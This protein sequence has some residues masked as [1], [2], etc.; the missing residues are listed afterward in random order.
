MNQTLKR[1]LGRR[2]ISIV[3]FLVL[4]ATSMNTVLCISDKQSGSSISPF[5]LTAG[6][7]HT[8]N[9]MQKES[10]I[11]T[12]DDESVKITV[13]SSEDII[14]ISYHINSFTSEI[15]KIH[16]REYSKIFLEDESNMKIK[17][18]PE[19]PTISQSIIIPDTAK[20]KIRVIDAQYEEY[21]NM[22]IIP[23]KGILPR[24][25][26]PEEVPY[27]FDRIYTQDTMFPP[28]IAELGEPYILRDF[29]GQVVTLYP[30]QYNPPR[31]ILRFYT[32][33]TIEI[34]PDGMDTVNCITRSE[35][36]S[37]IDTDFK[38][39]YEYHFINFPPRGRYTPVE[40]Q[41]NML[42]ITYDNFWDEMIPFVQWKN[43]KGVP[44]EMV[45]VSQIGGAYAIKTY[46]SD[47]YYDNGLTFVL[48]VG[49]VQQVPTL[50]AVGGASDPSYSYIVGYDHY[51]DLFVG[52]FS[53]QNTGQVETQ[54]ER[55]IEYEKYPQQGADWYH[56]G[57]GIASNEG[58]GDDW[59]YDW[60]HIRNI[61]TELLNYHYTLVDELYDG[62]HGGEDAPGN[63]SAG[64]VSTA[65]NNGRSVINYC[66]HGWGQGWVTTGFSN[67]HVNSLINDNM[68]PF[69][70]TVACN[71]GEFDSYTTC[72]AEAWLR[73]THG[74]EPTGAIA[75][76]AS[77]ISQYW[78]P[79]MDAQDEFVALL[80]ESYAN[81]KKNTFGGISF[82]GCMHMNDRYGSWGYDMTDT[83]HVFGDP[84][85]QVR[86]DTPAYMTVI[87]DPSIPVGSLTFEVDVLG[88]K[89]ALCAISRD[90]VLL[91]YGYT[92]DS[93][94]AIIEFD[95]PISDDGDVDLVVTAYNKIPYITSLD[96][97]SEI[98]GDLDGDGDV[99]QEDLGILLADWGCTGGGCPGDCDG[100][101]DT[102][103]ED[104]GILLSN[105]GYGT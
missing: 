90:Y 93:G 73:A 52:R 83:W 104:L 8:I 44:T 63:P 23:S 39:I 30:F 45:K 88:V 10:Q 20:M 77:S 50:Y 105:W 68:L 40:E 2:I 103:Q 14:Q 67:S 87:H 1:N 22:L 41:G 18:M 38:Q 3:L 95:E 79:P 13:M 62:S 101:G 94:H 25:V 46:I 26:N 86:T 84:S 81:N 64:M 37:V 28:T 34:F 51:P 32:D 80:V 71:N 53:A 29:R 92:D 96:V 6:G 11:S 12:Y 17:G 74:S 43:M 76:F 58:P 61:R 89:D 60:Q 48:L 21:D 100:D 47:Y 97:V 85:I 56:K 24:S 102:D 66:G 49:D 31:H 33:I 42:V 59:E 91:G 75:M 7:S 4:I 19:L 65:V 27:E 15:V 72:F 36:P 5:T 57:V 54:V 78:D 9:E 70:W 99:D 55:S 35:L 16:N 69:I 82:N 98:P